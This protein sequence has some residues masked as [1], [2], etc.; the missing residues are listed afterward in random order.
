QPLICEAR[1]FTSS[2]RLGSRLEAMV[3]ETP[4][5]AFISEGAAA[6]GSSLAVMDHLLPL[7]SGYHD[8]PESARVTFTSKILFGESDGRATRNFTSRHVQRDLTNMK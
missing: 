8:D 7:F 2:Q 4:C 6:K 1:I 5:Q 3:T